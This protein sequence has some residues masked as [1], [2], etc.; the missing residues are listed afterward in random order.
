MSEERPPTYNHTDLLLISLI[1]VLS[2]L[3]PFKLFSAILE[4]TIV[5]LAMGDQKKNKR[6]HEGLSQLSDTSEHHKRKRFGRDHV[7]NTQVQ[8]VHEASATMEGSSLGNVGSMSQPAGGSMPPSTPKPVGPRMSQKKQL[9]QAR[10]QKSTRSKQKPQDLP[11]LP[12]I[13]DSKLANA[14]FTHPTRLQGHNQTKLDKSYDRLEFLGDAYIELVASRLVYKRYP[15]MAA[16]ALSQQRE[17]L[18]KNEALAAHSLAYGFDKRASLPPRVSGISLPVSKRRLNDPEKQYVKMLG[19]VF[20]A[21]VAGVVLSNASSGYEI[22]EEW[23]HKLM[24]PKLEA[25]NNDEVKEPPPADSKTQLSKRILGQ[26]A[27][28]EYCETAAPDLS[29]SKSGITWFTIGAFLTGWGWDRVKLGEGRAKTKS[30]AG[31]IAATQAREN[32]V[33]EQIEK[34]KREHD[35]K[36]ATER[37]AQATKDDMQEGQTHFGSES[38]SQHPNTVEESMG[39]ERQLPDGSSSSDDSDDSDDS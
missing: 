3:L 24:L 27:R 38:S 19:D 33:T 28:L 26:G 18:I 14:V 29:E 5:S 7:H 37:A 13:T 4:R 25:Q 39:E 22:V 16:G 21:Y 30:K 6:P 36:V 15:F 2:F 23:L 1:T 20:E 31:M 35:R 32:P 10:P 8:S 17:R 34:I 12:L 9:H 11:P